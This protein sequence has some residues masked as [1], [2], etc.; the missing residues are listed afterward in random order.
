MIV[1]IATNLTKG[2]NNMKVRVRITVEVKS[3]HLKPE[4]I[5]REAKEGFEFGWSFNNGRLEKVESKISEF[6][7]AL[8]KAS[9]YLENLGSDYNVD[10]SRIQK[11]LINQIM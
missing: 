1:S 4:F 7:S 2:N 3:R 10:L 9:R 6:S 11:E 8:Y 5:L